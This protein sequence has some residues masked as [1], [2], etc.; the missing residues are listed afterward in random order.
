MYCLIVSYSSIEHFG[1]GRY[2]DPIDPD[3]DLKW[4]K[5]IRNCLAPGGRL[6]I[7]VPV[8]E[9]DQVVECWHRI[10][11]PTRLARL[12]EGWSIVKTIPAPKDVKHDWQNQ[13][14]M[15]LVPA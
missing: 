12:L 15:T 8:G 1:L 7:G 3:A 6:V 13:P 4:M 10:Y 11:G 5:M 9:R 2:G 14:V